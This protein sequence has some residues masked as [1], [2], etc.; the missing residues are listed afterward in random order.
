MWQWNI[1]V[2]RGA[3]QTLPILVWKYLHPINNFGNNI[4]EWF[5]FFVSR[6]MEYGHRG[7]TCD[8]S[9]QEQKNFKTSIDS[10]VI[11]ELV[12]QGYKVHLSMTIIVCKYN[13]YSASECCVWGTNDVLR[14]KISLVAILTL[15]VRV[16][17]EEFP[18]RLM[19]NIWR[20]HDI[21][22]LRPLILTYKCSP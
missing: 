3:I 9:C 12:K 8:I 4:Y 7:K 21:V 16:K 22:P 2:C 15:Q 20:F 11:N 10:S 6:Q 19:R 14:I 5:A 17:N 13:N 1:G 18:V